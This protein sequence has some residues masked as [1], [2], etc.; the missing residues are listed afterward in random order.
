MISV[1]ILNLTA[2]VVCSSYSSRGWA[3][4]VDTATLKGSVSLSFRLPECLAQN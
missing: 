1:T 3:G 4:G 2:D